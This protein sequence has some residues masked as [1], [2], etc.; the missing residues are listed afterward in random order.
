MTKCY[1]MAWMSPEGKVS[2]DDVLGKLDTIA[3][4]VN[5]RASDGAIFIVSEVEKAQ[6]IAD[7]IHD[8]IPEI[9]FVLVPTSISSVWGWAEH[10]TWAFLRKREAA[11]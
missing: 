5:W 8:L 11:K 3:E 4:I 7:K 10:D 2:R 9:N 1:T 6:P